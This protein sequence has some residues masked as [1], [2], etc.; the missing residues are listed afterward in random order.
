MF[1]HFVRTNYKLFVV[2][3]IYS[4]HVTPSYILLFAATD[5]KIHL[6][7]LVII[8]SKSSQ[9][10]PRLDLNIIK[11]MEVKQKF[12]IENKVPAIPE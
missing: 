4:E 12:A 3:P 2:S 8:G 5:F 11:Q 9:L 10:L 6:Y 1:E 7:K